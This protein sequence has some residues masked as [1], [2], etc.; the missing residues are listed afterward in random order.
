MKASEFKTKCLQ[1]LDEV[2][3]TGEPVRIT[4]RGK[5]VAQVVQHMPAGGSVVDRL[6]KVFPESG[7]SNRPSAFDVREGI[8]E[9]WRRWE[10]RMDRMLSPTR[11][12]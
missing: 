2:Q 3:A 9:E 4:K 12:E 8:E 10:E 6:R 5:V 11:D 7:K 1:V